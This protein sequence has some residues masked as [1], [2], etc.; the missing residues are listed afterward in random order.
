MPHRVKAF[1]LFQVECAVMK[2]LATYKSRN[3]V[4]EAVSVRIETLIIMV[5]EV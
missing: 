3:Q 1:G 5:L 2:T 4:L